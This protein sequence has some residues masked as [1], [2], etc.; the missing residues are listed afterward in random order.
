MEGEGIRRQSGGAQRRQQRRWAGN[1]GHSDAKIAGL[2]HQ[3][4]AWVGNQ[5]RSRVRNQGDVFPSLQF[6]EKVNRARL[7]VV[8]VITDQRGGD[9]VSLQQLMRLASVFARDEIH[10]GERADPAKSNIFEISD[11]GRNDVECA[12][13]LSSAYS[14][15]YDKNAE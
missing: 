3:A 7:L 1:R 12:A 5:R 9:L 14:Q 13:H 15:D 4:V 8:F 2:L 10:F 11:R 6:A